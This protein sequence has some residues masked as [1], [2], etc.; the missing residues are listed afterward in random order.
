MERLSGKDLLR[1]SEFLRELYILRN[2]D[3][4]TTHLISALPTITEGDFTAYNELPYDARKPALAKSDQM[5][6]CSNPEYYASVIAMY[7]N[8]HPILCYMR[9]KKDG[10]AKTYSDFLSMREW[11]RTAVYNEFYWPLRIPYLLAMAL[12]VGRRI[13]TVSRH[14]DGHEFHD[15]ARTMFNVVRPHIR[16]AM[17][18]ALA[19]S[20]MKNH[21]SFTDQAMRL[22]GQSVL[23]ATLNGHIKFSTPSAQQL[24]TKYGLDSRPWPNRLPPRIQTW[25]KYQDEHLHSPADVPA[26]IRPLIIPSYGGALH[27]RCFREQTRYLLVLEEHRRDV[28][29]A[30]LNHLGLS[31]RETEVLRWVVGNKT[32]PE[33]GTILG[34]SPRTVQKHLERIYVRL[35]VENRAAAASVAREAEHLS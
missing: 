19:V 13:I 21:L 30:K 1:L 20:Q 7:A 35:G 22:R 4:F 12:T 14:R 18:N 8:Q 26:P 32:N 34:I 17:Q 10:S 28:L 15:R 23:S 3:E 25:L 33:I 9:E 6:H 24:F 5:A 2:H 11:R 16:Q 27:I 29:Q 31:P